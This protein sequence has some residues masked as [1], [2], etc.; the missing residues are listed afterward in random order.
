MPLSLVI[1]E[2]PTPATSL[3][4]LATRD[5]H[6]IN[7]VRELLLDRLVDRPAG[8]MLSIKDARTRPQQEVDSCPDDETVA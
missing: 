1:L 8:K 2:G 7:A 6:I 3:P 4:I 5:P